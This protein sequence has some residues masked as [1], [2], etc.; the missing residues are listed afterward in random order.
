MLGAYYSVMAL[1]VVVMLLCDYML[2]VILGGCLN[3][4]SLW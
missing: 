4:F 2:R 3:C 1:W